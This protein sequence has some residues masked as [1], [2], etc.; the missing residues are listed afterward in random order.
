MVPRSEED[1]AQAFDLLFTDHFDYNAAVGNTR[2]SGVTKIRQLGF[3]TAS[4]YS[5]RLR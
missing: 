2:K 5:R 4:G 3:D 1:T